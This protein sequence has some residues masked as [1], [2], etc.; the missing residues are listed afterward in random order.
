MRTRLSVRAGAVTFVMLLPLWALLL[1]AQA[2]SGAKPFDPK[3]VDPQA[4]IK[5][6][7]EAAKAELD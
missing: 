2:P 1:A 3:A 4:S 5:A 6:A 7:I